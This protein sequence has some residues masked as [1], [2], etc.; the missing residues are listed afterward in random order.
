MT[1]NFKKRWWRCPAHLEWIVENY[2]CCVPGCGAWAQEAHHVRDMTDGGMKR[3]PS[4]RWAVPLC[5]MHHRELHTRGERRF[6]RWL[7]TAGWRVAQGYYV[8]SPHKDA[9]KMVSK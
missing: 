3:K 1:A 9:G 4:D 8:N 6:W 5:A 2:Q 7:G